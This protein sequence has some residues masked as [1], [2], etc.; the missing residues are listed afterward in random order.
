[1]IRSPFRLVQILVIS[2]WLPSIF[3]AAPVELRITGDWEVK[4]VLPVTPASPS[5]PVAIETM[6]HV[7]PPASITVTAERYDSLPRF[8]PKA[9]GWAKSAQ[10]RGVRAQ[11]TTTP[12]LLDPA[13]LVLRSGPGADAEMYQAG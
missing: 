8:N 10:L 5:A 3:A 11:E 7:P 2:G 4:A 12:F 6:L 1:M 13:S 9:G